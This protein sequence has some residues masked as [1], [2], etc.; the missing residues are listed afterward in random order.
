MKHKFLKFCT[1]SVAALHGINTYIDSNIPHTSA[2]DEG[3]YYHWDNGDLFYRKA[4][5]GAPLLLLHDINVFSS[6]SEWSQVIGQ[7]SKEHT[8]YAP[9]FLGCG[10]SEKPSGTY[11]TYLY[12]Q[13]LSTFVKNV[14]KEQ[15]DV[16]SSGL[17]A[18]PV[19]MADALDPDLFG[20]IQ[21]INP[22]A[23]SSL[24]AS[25]DDFSRLYIYLSEVPVIGRTCYYAAVNRTNT[26]DY[27]TEKC[28][29]NPFELKQATVQS[30]YEASH[31]GKG[32]GR[33]LLASL[34]GNYLNTDISSALQS[35]NKSVTIYF[36]EYAYA[37]DESA[38]YQELN[39]NL[40]VKTFPG[41][42]RMPH[43]ER[44]DLFCSMI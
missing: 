11:T 28:F 36:S 6:S 24:K 40:V 32:G 25:P 26:E 2:S 43:V 27:L 19:I 41:T 23:L 29:Y 4:G 33:Y 3:E 34:N 30:A 31:L 21:M 20:S 44:P 15:T 17:A 7:L 1:A 5:E 22:P 35:T 10:R 42:K 13:M 16:V 39:E 37:N 8:V 12:V 38:A 14:I 18:L 9:D